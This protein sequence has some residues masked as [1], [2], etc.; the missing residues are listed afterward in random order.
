MLEVEDAVL[1][2]LGRALAGAAVQLLVRVVVTGDVASL[3]AHHRAPRLLRA[4]HG[5]HHHHRCSHT[6]RAKKEKVGF[7]NDPGV[8]G[9]AA[10][11][12]R[13]SKKSTSPFYLRIAKN[14]SEVF[15]LG[16]RKTRVS[17]GDSRPYR[18]WIRPVVEE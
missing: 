15:F 13:D 8:T 17:S 16:F 14:F 3:D 9:L 11:L 10:D 2:V 18:S 12:I 5:A 4:A 6:K 7:R 1:A